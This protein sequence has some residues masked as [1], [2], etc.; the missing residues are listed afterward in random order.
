MTVRHWLVIFVL[1]I[2]WGSSFFFNEILLRELGPIT[3]GLGRVGMGAIG[4]WLWLSVRRVS[5]AVPRAVSAGAT[6]HVVSSSFSRESRCP[7]LKV[8][9]SHTRT[10]EKSSLA[11]VG[12]GRRPFW[13]VLV[14]GSHVVVQRVHEAEAGGAPKPLASYSSAGLAGHVQQEQ[15]TA[16]AAQRTEA[17][18]MPDTIAK[19]DTAVRSAHVRSERAVELCRN[20]IALADGVLRRGAGSYVVIEF[21]TTGILVCYLFYLRGRFD[22]IHTRIRNSDGGQLLTAADFTV[23]VSHVPESWGSQQ[24]RDFFEKFGEVVHVGFSLNNRELVLQI[25]AGNEMR[26]SDRRL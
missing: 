12:G 7:S 15:Q 6:R 23:M 3:V 16:A 17:A 10:I 20:G 13:T 19:I 26:G 2:G 18:A 8:K 1:G 21:F 5:G 9:P 11:S 24:L 4:C 14:E 22:E 25:K